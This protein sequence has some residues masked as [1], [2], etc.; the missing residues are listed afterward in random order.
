[1][2]NIALSN[3]VPF[4][5]NGVHSHAKTLLLSEWLLEMS[6]NVHI[7][8]LDIMDRRRHSIARYIH[9]IADLHFVIRPVTLYPMSPKSLKS[10]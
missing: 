9:W 7:F 5:I 1:M 6:T 2:S 10:S 8:P 4:A 3:I